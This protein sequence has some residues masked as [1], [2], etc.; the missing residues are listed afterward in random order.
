MLSKRVMKDGHGCCHEKIIN[1]LSYN[2]SGLR[3][4]LTP[5]LSLLIAESLFSR[6]L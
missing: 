5:A 2:S 3:P 1:V 6:T 4:P